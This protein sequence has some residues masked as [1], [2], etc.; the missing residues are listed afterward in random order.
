MADDEPTYTEPG[1]IEF[2]DSRKVDL[3]FDVG[4]NDGHF[5]LWLRE[6]GYR[7]GIVSFE[8]I[9]A[10]FDRLEARAQEDEAWEA[11]PV[12][13]GEKPGTARINVSASA[14]FSS[15]RPHREA[16]TTFDPEAVPVRTEEIA[17][18]TLDAF[19]PLHAGRTCFLKIDTQ[20]FEQQVL[21]GARATLPMLQ[22]VQ[23][24]LPIIH[25]YSGV[26]GMS[27]AISFMAGQGFVVAQIRPVNYHPGDP[28]SW[29]EA[30][31]LFRRADA[32]ID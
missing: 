21:L 5:G 8:P 15:L 12:A 29:V 23:L 4:A 28:V 20:G 17:I 31:C 7:G 19:A 32:R 13:L 30:D 24:E 2:L 10:L 22:G 14:V 1:L 26:W 25:L 11:H 3:V 9:R 18:A 27:E 6:S 16:A